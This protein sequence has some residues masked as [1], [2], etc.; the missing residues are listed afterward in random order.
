M[1]KA[2]SALASGKAAGLNKVP[3]EAFK[4]LNDKNLTHLHKFFADFW[5]GRAN[6]AEWHEG[7]LVPVPKSGD[8]A[9]PNKW[10]GV[11]LMDIGSKIFSKILC[12]RLFMIIKQHG[13][14]YQFGSTPGVGCQDGT[15]TLKTILHLRHSHNLPTWVCF[16]DLVKAFDT[17]NHK[18]LIEILK[19][20]GCPPKLCSAI[21]RMYDDSVVRLIIGKCDTSIPFK[22]GVKQGDSM[23]PVL[24]LFLI[25]AFAETLEK[26]WTAQ[27][28]T[29]ATF[30][31]RSNSPLCKG[32][33]IS[34]S[35]KSFREGTLFQV[36]TMLYVDGGA[37]V[38]ESRQY[39][40]KGVGIIWRQF[41]KFALEMHTGTETKTSKTEFVFFHPQ[42]FSSSTYF[43][44]NQRKETR[45]PA[46][47]P[48]RRLNPRKSEGKEKTGYMILWRKQEK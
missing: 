9:D 47:R 31:R 30:N 5:D 26:E 12:T 6:F 1:K 45:T 22:V 3:P 16:A 2:I 14:K 32:Q 8:L 41:A 27:G 28:L 43:D 21:K 38:F 42:N 36:F 23:A 25:M 39:L 20:Y 13:V 11:T 7:Q 10:R 15:F 17:S 18:L 40:E 37:F 29:K 19:R 46:S 24:F 34:H 44:S 48:P 33:L 4:A 35:P